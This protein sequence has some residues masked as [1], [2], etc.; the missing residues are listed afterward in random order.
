MTLRIKTYLFYYWI[1]LI[2]LHSCTNE[3]LENHKHELNTRDYQPF[4]INHAQG[5]SIQQ[6][7]NVLLLLIHDVSTQRVI[8]SLLLAADINKGITIFE[9]CVAQSTTYLAYYQLIEAQKQLIG[10]C[11]VSY[12]SQAKTAQYDEL[13]EICNAQGINHEKIVKLQPDLVF[14]YPFGDK[15]QAQIRRLGITTL[16]LTEYLETTPLARAEWL[17]LFALLAGKNPNETAFE[18]IEKAYLAKRFNNKTQKKLP[19]VVFN[20]PY[21][22]TWDMP[23]HHSISAQ[24]VRDAGLDYTPKKIST[25]GNLLFKKEEVY[26]L[27]ETSEYWLIIAERQANFS[28][29]DL[30]SENRIYRTFPSVQNKRV[31]F[32]NTAIAP[33]FSEGPIEPHVLLGDL[34]NCIA[35]KSDKQ[36]YFNLLE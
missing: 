31:I 20:L 19:S 11:G 17:K 7:G 3:H 6:K 13:Q 9:R 30:I 24:F 14:L 16:F 10:L 4:D 8:D 18:P 28:L 29:S 5:F 35:G 26:A 27:L 34:Q 12:V 25:R 15:D 32:C 33:Y 2:G 1:L 21:G 23:A 36:K 22:D